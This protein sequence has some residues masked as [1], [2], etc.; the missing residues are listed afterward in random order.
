MVTARRTFRLAEQGSSRA[1]R[2][3]PATPYDATITDIIPFNEFG[4]LDELDFSN[5]CGV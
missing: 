1:S 5:T 3:T 2:G 4:D